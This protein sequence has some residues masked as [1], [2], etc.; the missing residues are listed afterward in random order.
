MSAKCKYS[1]RTAFLHSLTAA[2][3]YPPLYTKHF[4]H[5]RQVVPKQKNPDWYSTT[6]AAGN[7]ELFPGLRLTSAI[8][9]SDIT[10]DTTGLPGSMIGHPA[11]PSDH[12]KYCNH[13]LVN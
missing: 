3:P 4:R 12:N 1:D 2:S 6:S 10:W 13:R 5:I 8:G 7:F 11:I 9:T